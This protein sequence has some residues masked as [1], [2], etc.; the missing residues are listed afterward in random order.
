MQYYTVG[1]QSLHILFIAIFKGPAP[2]LTICAQ[3]S[4]TKNVFTI[5]SVDA[6]KITK[7]KK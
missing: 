6:I 5:R 1:S 3:S 2:D 4:W 7:L